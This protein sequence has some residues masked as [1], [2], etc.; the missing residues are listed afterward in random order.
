MRGGVWGGSSD[1]LRV[2]LLW[3]IAAL[4]GGWLEE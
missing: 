2:G 3:H 4:Q 1:R